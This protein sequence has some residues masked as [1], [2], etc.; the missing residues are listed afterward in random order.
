[1]KTAKRVISVLMAALIVLSCWIWLAPENNISEAATEAVK[2]HYLFAYFTGTSKEGQTIHLAVSED[3]YNYTAL[4]NNEPVIIPSKGVGSVRDP[5]IWYNEQDNYYYII[6]TDLDFTDTDS[7]Y[8]DNSQS[9]II[10]RS[11]DLINWYDETFIDVNA[12]AHLIGDT[13]NMINVWA[14]QILWDGSAYV[15]YFTLR[16][17]ATAND[18]TGWN[19]MQIVYLKTSDLLDKNAY[20]EYGVIYDNHNQIID[21]DIIQNPA[22]GLWYLFHKNEDWDYDTPTTDLKT[23]FYVVSENATGPY[24]NIHPVTGEN[25]DTSGDTSGISRGYRVYPNTT[26]SLEGCNSFFDN[27]GNLITYTDEFGHKNALNEDEAYFHISKSSDF[28]TFTMLDDS[29]HNINSLSPRHGSVVKITE[30]EYNRLLNNSYNITS[31]SFPATETLE[32]HLVARYFTTADASENTVVGQPDLSTV[33]D[34]TMEQDVTGEYYAVFNGTSSYAETDFDELFLKSNGLNY[35]DGFTITFSAL[36]FPMESE[37]SENNDRIYEIANIF[38]DQSS[39]DAYYTHFSPS[40]GGTGS[41][42]GNYNG[43][44]LAGSY[45]WIADKDGANRDDNCIHEYIISYA[46]GNVMV[47]VDGVLVMSKNRYNYKQPAPLDDSWFKALGSDATMRIGKSGWDPDPLFQGYMQDLCIYDVSMSY[48]DAKSLDEDL[49]VDQGW[50]GERTYNGITSAV[51]SFNGTNVTNEGTYYDNILYTSH[52]T[53]MPTGNGQGANPTAGSNPAVVW[54]NIADVYF[55]VYYA[56]TTVLLLDGINEAKMP[57]FFGGR[58]N[59]DDKDRFFYSVYPT[60]DYGVNTDNKEIHFND[61]WIGY[62]E[63]PDFGYV[64]TNNRQTMGWKSGNQKLYAEMGDGNSQSARYIRYYA[65]MLTVDENNIDFEGKYYKK[66]NLSW[67]YYGGSSTTYTETDANLKGNKISDNDIYV[68]NFKPILDLRAQI[69]ENEYNSVMNNSALCPELKEKYA[70]AVYEIRTLN[71]TNFGFAEAPETA[72]KACGKAIGE[73]I[74]TYEGVMAEIAREEAADSYGHQCTEFEAREATCAFNGLTSGKYCVLCGEILEEQQVIASLPHTFGAVFTE[75]GIQY[76]ECSECGVRIEYQPGEVRYENLFS[77]NRWD[78]SA[79]K[80]IANHS[81][82]SVTTN[83]INGTITIVNNNTAEVYTRA[84]FDGQNLVATRDFGCACIPVTGGKTYV[85]EAT[86]LASSTSAGDVFVFQYNKDGSVFQAIPGLISNL[87]AGATGK[88]EFTVDTNA[89]YIELRFD[90]NDAG[91]TITFSQIGVYE[92]ENFDKFGATTA[93]ARLGFYPGDDKALCYPNPAV[94]YVF[95]GWY[96]SNGMLV[97]N[98]NQLN[99]PSTIVYGKWIKAGYNVVYDSIFSFSDWAKSSCNQLWYGDSKDA[100]GNTVRLVSKEGILADAANGTI[101]IT[102]D[103]DTTNFART[104]LWHD[105]NNRY[106]ITVEANT[107]YVIEYTATSADNAKSSVCAYFFGGTAV[108]AETGMATKYGLGTQRVTVNSGNNTKLVMRF[109]NIEHGSTLTYSD[110]AIYKADFLEAAQTIT[111]R[112]Y[113]RYYPQEMGIGDVFEYTP[114]RPGFTFDTWMA[115]TNSDN[116]GDFNMAGFDDAFIVNQN[117]HLFSTWTENGYNIA[118]NANGGSGSIANQTTLY[119]ADVTLAADGFTRDG[120][121]LAGW[122]T[123]P[124]ATVATYQRGQT[125][126]RLCG[127]KDG[128]ITLYAVWTVQKINVTFDNLVDFNAWP[129]TAGNGTMSDITDTGFTITSNEGAGEATSS[130]AFFPVTPGKQYK[131]DIDFT[132]DN[133]D[134]YIFF[135]NEAGTWIDFADSTNRFSS[136]GSGVASRVFTAPNKPEVVKAQIRVDA[137][138]SNNTV[139]FENIRVSEYTDVAVSPVNKFVT[140]NTAYGELPTPTKYGYTFKG[141]FD[142][143]G[144]RITE[145]AVVTQGTTVFLNSKWVVGDSSLVAD[146]VV[147]DFGT[148]I[149][150][151]PLSNDTIFMNEVTA[152]GGTYQLLGVSTDGTNYSSTLNATYGTFSVNGNEVTYTPSATVSGTEIIYYH[153]SLT[154]NGTTTA[155]KSEITV[156]PASNILYEE[157]S[158]AVANTTGLAWSTVKDDSAA[159]NGNQS[160]S[161]KYDIYGY[162]ASYNSYRDYSNGSALK[163]NVDSTNKRSQILSFDF[164]GT[165]FEL[166]GAC[167]PDTG[168]QIVTLKNNDTGKMV[169]SY[170][171]DTYYGDSTYGTLY[172]VPI[173]NASDLSYGNYTV[174]VMA[175]YLTLAGALN[176]NVSTQAVEGF[177]GMT[178]NSASAANNKALA[179]NLAE[180]G[181]DYILDADELDVVWFDD[182]SILNGGNGVNTVAQDMLTTEA[183]TS[184]LNVVDSIRVYNPILNDGDLYYISS[185]TCAQYYNVMDN[186]VNGDGVVSGSGN[187][188]YVS[189]GNDNEEIKLDTY[190]AIGSKDE[191]YLSESTEAVTFTIAGLDDNSKVMISLRAASGT[192]TVKIGEAEMKITSNTEMYYN[193]TDYIKDGTVTIQNKAEDTNDTEKSLLAVGYV[194]ITGPALATMSTFNL[195]TAREMMMA[196]STEVDLNA[197]DTD[198]DVSTPED[199]T[200]TDTDGSA[201]EEDT[202]ADTDDSTDEDTTECWLVKFFKWVIG[203]FIKIIEIIKGLFSF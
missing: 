20:Y 143:S 47:Y 126:N 102:N 72:T 67:Q 25:L 34:I 9:F 107:D 120:Y 182:D 84:T 141:W 175:S 37:N 24:T 108:A 160:A 65:N 189:G 164:T 14:P 194:K 42:L 161:T 83:Q 49:T 53:G 178:V 87:A 158:L 174:Q 144:T 167:G 153:A 93:D 1:M 131:V 35:E 68:I 11:K 32:D 86:S 69:T 117:W 17:N 169:K 100:N 106:E 101:T 66:I 10:W 135:C 195:L 203:C 150:I 181:M 192:P 58:Q 145:S 57:V 154:A 196:P 113:R 30:E 23:I 2:D 26:V 185:E 111:N 139:T 38:G 18:G 96:T 171:V 31:S 60:S 50:V 198:D 149:G 40:G 77:L 52:P 122:S 184:L 123:E 115:D 12:M 16:C 89:A 201:P 190:D 33:T 114:V 180:I 59:N 173:L 133:W 95:D 22:D 105:Q 4:R 172:Q 166:Y 163:V 90:A 36:N 94:G 200:D 97:E 81:G 71:P 176:S 140:Y 187:F 74:G 124:N 15:V 19:N 43:P 104:N 79:S 98:V 75:N 64:Y 137:N 110:I 197:P 168:I 119:T 152:T 112:Q 155:V 202:D 29:I 128:T 78:S 3:G 21:A 132:G 80:A 6:A 55:G 193:I 91:K 146:V 46:T 62:H 142:E 27:D 54:E 129:K 177:G 44:V 125:T 148:P 186:L 159:T 156:A 179:E 39:S 70:A 82:S 138:G 92:K 151:A 28:K 76:R 127:D 188:A 13:R 99:N 130:S 118:Y 88:V 183:V 61:K 85:V 147:V 109:D 121:S 7:N 51:P 116:V 63:S 73:A 103:A 136:N 45:D 162:D 191:L 8:S 170:I 56:E 199:G 5:Y 134:V 165:G 41:Y 157:N 48:Y